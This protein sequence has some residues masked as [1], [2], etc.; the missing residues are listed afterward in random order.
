MARRSDH[1]R[2]ELE[3]MAI[4]AGLE[5]LEEGGLAHFSARKVATKIGY[6]IGTIYNVF[7]THDNFLLKM[8]ARTLDEWYER[9]N[10]AAH[11]PVGNPLHNIAHAYIAYS[12]EHYHRWITLFEHHMQDDAPLPSWFTPKITRFFILVEDILRREEGGDEVALKRGARMLWSAI[13]GI[14]VLSATKKLDLV[15]QESADKLAIESVDYFIA[16]VNA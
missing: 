14:A 6:T 1:T 4:Q 10:A 13:H 5:L 3:E 12:R 7:G 9:M 16:G 15:T 8:N 11:N 2:A